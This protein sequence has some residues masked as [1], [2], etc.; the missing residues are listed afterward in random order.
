MADPWWVEI[1]YS[2]I[3]ILQ[4]NYPK[5]I[6]SAKKPSTGQR[7]TYFVSAV[8]GPFKTKQEATNAAHGYSGILNE[9]GV[10]SGGGSGTGT[11]GDIGNFFHRLSEKQTWIRV[12]E[13]ALGGILLYVGVHAVAQ[14]SAIKTATKSGSKSITRPVRKATKATVR[15]ALPQA[16]PVVRTAKARAKV[17]ART[18]TTVTRKTTGA[19]DNRTVTTT[20]KHTYGRRP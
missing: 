19:P 20:T 3:N 14:G 4:L 15:V 18:G 7:L 11:L 10:G 8:Q 17:K 16:T 2:E 13:V 5:V 12:G 6:Q 9:G 1:I